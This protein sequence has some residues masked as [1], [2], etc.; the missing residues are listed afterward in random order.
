MKR[1]LFDQSFAMSDVIRRVL[2]VW[3]LNNVAAAAAAAAAAAD[4]EGAECG[5]KDGVAGQR[6]FVES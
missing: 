3:L 5:D 1:Y 4:V 6:T 2:A